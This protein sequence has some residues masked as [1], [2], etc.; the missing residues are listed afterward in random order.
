MS[1]VKLNNKIVKLNG[2]IVTMTVPSE[3]VADYDGNI[4]DVVTIG[5]QKWTAQNLKTTHYNDGTPIPQISNYNDWFLPSKDELLVMH[6]ELYL[7]S[8]GSL[9]A[10]YYVS[11]SEQ[12]APYDVDYIWLYDMLNGVYGGALKSEYGTGRLVRA[13]RAFTSVSPSYNLRDIGPAG[14]WIFWKSGNDYLEAAPT[15]LPYD[16]LLQWSNIINAA[17]GTGTAVGTGQANTTAIISQVGH[18]N[19]VAKLC[20]DL[21][22]DM[23]WGQDING[24]YCYYSNDVLNKP[25]YG[26]LYNWYCVDNVHGLAPTGWRVPSNTDWTTLTTYLGGT[27]VAGGKLKE[28]GTTH[29]ASPNTDAT[30]DYGFTVL[31][32]GYRHHSNG[33]FSDIFNQAVFFSSTSRDATRAW[34]RIL[35]RDGAYCVTW[36]GYKRYGYSIR[37]IKN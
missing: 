17:V 35:G 32:G 12:D 34:D 33:G 1:I 36:D 5:T 37:F 19:S 3:T 16:A 2:K 18:T 28:V 10:A 13:I 8:I 30:D 6:D 26:G 11:S 4:Y 14:G 27:S 25:V 29:W 31:P 9:L 24:A 23:L 22:S 21:T 20:D 15:N 7:Y